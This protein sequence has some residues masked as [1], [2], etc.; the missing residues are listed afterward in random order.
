MVRTVVGKMT[1]AKQDGEHQK[2]TS[3]KKKIPLSAQVHTLEV[4]VH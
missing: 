2:Y 4:P 1:A 3:L